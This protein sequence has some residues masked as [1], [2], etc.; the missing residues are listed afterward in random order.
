MPFAQPYLQTI[1]SNIPHGTPAHIILDKSL[2]AYLRLVQIETYKINLALRWRVFNPLQQLSDME[3]HDN[4]HSFKTLENKTVGIL[5]YLY[6]LVL[7]H[8]PH[9]I[10][11]QTP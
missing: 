6:V 5:Q 4:L 9:T 1:M 3:L 8:R 2:T 7:Q 11:N 10:N